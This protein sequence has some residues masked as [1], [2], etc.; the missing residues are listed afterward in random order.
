[1]IYS[2]IGL[3]LDLI[4]VL[5]LFQFGILPENL[6]NHILWDNEMSDKDIARHTFWSKIGAILLITGF[7]SVNCTV[8]Q[9]HTIKIQLLRQYLKSIKYR[10]REV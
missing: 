6:W 7:I 1:M 3:I 4:G 10:F 9:N 8:V 5:L 2:I